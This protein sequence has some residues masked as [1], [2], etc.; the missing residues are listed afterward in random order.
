MQDAPAKGLWSKDFL[1]LISSNLLLCLGI[2]MLPATLPAYVA[3]IGGSAF[4]TS[5]VIGAFSILSM[6]TR[7]A[8]GVIFDVTGEKSII[9]IGIASIAATTFL[10]IWMPVNGILLMRGIQ[11]V[12]WGLATSAIATVVYKIVPES[13]RGEGAGYYALTVIVPVSLSPLVAI[14]VMDYFEF[15]KV[16]AVSALLTFAG[17]ATLKQGL[18]SLAQH[19]PNPTASRGTM[20]ARVFEGG[21]VLPSFLCFILS[22]P[23]CGVMAYIVLYGRE[24]QV[25]NIWLFFVGYAAMILVTR[26]M[27]GRL[28]DA[29]G[30]A[31]I[32][33][34]GSAAMLLGLIALSQTRSITMLVVS[35]L[36]FGLGYGA[37]QPSLQTW[38]V[39]RCPPHRKAAANGLFMSA[40]DLGYIVGSITLGQIAQSQ[41]FAAMYLYAAGI[42]MV[43]MLIYL[44]N[45]KTPVP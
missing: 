31:A 25:Q 20:L 43:F 39:N 8:S 7:M 6:A 30:H 44:K 26:T 41:G 34:P 22:V 9:W 23:L 13:Q 37:V 27:I 11:G 5:L 32:I 4:Q 10:M 28:F 15:K 1:G 36:L 18:S 45:W 16:L 3:G 38:A 29:K 17:L 24:Q 12:G 2:Y 33:L 21:A 40:I 35:S 19:K 42:M 14:V